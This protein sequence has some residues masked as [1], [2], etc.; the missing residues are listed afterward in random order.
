MLESLVA[1]VLNR[2]LGSYVENFDPNQLKIGIWSGDVKLSNLKLKKE[3]LDKFNLPIDLKCGHLGQLTLQIPWSNLKGLPVKILIED[4]YLLAAGRIPE[5]INVEEDIQRELNVKKQKL[6]SLEVIQTQKNQLEVDADSK[7]QSFVESLTTKII[8]NLQVTIKN[9]HFRYEDEDAFSKYPYAVGATLS[10]LSAVSANGDW[11][12]SFIENVTAISKKLLTLNSLTVYWDTEHPE[13]VYSDDEDEVLRK[14]KEIIAS[15]SSID[16]NVEY[17]LEPV[18]GQ[19]RLTVNKVGSQEN[20]PHYTLDLFFE[21]FK[22]GLTSLQYRDILDTL[23]RVEWYRKTYKYKKFRPTVPVKEDPGKWLKYAFEC[24]YDEIHQRNYK[25]TWE[26]IAKRRDQRVEYVGLWVKKITDANSL[27]NDEKQRIAQLEIDCEYEDLKFYRSMARAKYRESHPPTEPETS[28]KQQGWFSSWWSGSPEESKDIPSD[29]QITEEQ[30]NEFFNAIEFDENKEVADSFDIPRDRILTA[31]GCSL[32][33]GS[34]TIKDSQASPPFAEFISNGGK[35]D[36]F[37]RKDSYY[38]GFKLNEFRVEDGSKTTM[39]KHIVSVKPF[40]EDETSDDTKRD[41]LFQLSYEHNPL[42]E[43]AD[44]ELLAKL[45]SMTIFHNPKFIGQIA[46]FFQPPKAHESTFDS[47]INAAETTFSD[48]TKMTRI[49]IQSAFENHKT[50]NCKMDLQA[51]LIILPVDASNWNS[52]VA[53][54]DAGHISVLSDLVDKDRIDKIRKEKKD[55][56]TDKDWENIGIYMYDKFKLVLQDARILIG[57][58]IKS[59]IEQLNSNGDKPSMI[60]DNLTMNFLIEASIIPNLAE[61]PRIRI[62]GDIPILKAMLNDYQYRIFM[63]IVDMEMIQMPKDDSTD[64]T[65]SPGLG[66]VS[67]TGP[68]SKP[69]YFN[70][71][72][73]TES[74][75]EIHE[76]SV[77]DKQHQVEL[78]F[79]MDKII[80]SLKRCSDPSTYESDVLVD[81]IGDDF[82]LKFYNTSNDMNVDLRLAD[83]SIDDF[84]ENSSIDEFKKLVCHKPNGNTGDDLF[85]LKFKRTLRLVPFNDEIIECYD[86]DIDL[87][88]SDFQA[89]LTRKSVLT[90]LNYSLNTF[91]DPLAPDLPSDKLRHNQ[92]QQVSN[93]PEHI[94]LNLRLKSFNLLLNDYGE[95]LA[96]IVLEDAKVGMFLLP[97]SMKLNATI[98]GFSLIDNFRTA[99]QKLISIQ[100]DDLGNLH[101]ETFDP[102]T[103]IR[104]YGSEFMF[105][106]KSLIVWFMED[107]FNRLYTFLSQFQQMKYVYDQAREAALDQANNVEYPDNTKFQILIRAPI[108]IFPKVLDP[109]T[110]KYDSITANLGEISIVNKF[111]VEDDI[112]FNLMTASLRNTKISSS[113][114]LPN[115]AIQNLDIIDQLDIE[116]DINSYTG[117]TLD[118]P[119]I[120]AKGGI[121]GKEI[122]LTEWQAFTLLQI[123]KYFPRTFETSNVAYSELEEI[124]NDALDANMMIRDKMI[125]SSILSQN[126]DSKIIELPVKDKNVSSESKTSPQINLSFHIP[127]LSMTLFNDTKNSED[128]AT[129][130]L[131]KFA[132]NEIG[133][134]FSLNSDGSYDSNMHVKSFVVDDLREEGKN[135]FTSIMPGVDFTDFQFLAKV[136]SEIINGQANTNLTILID[137]PKLLLAMDYFIALKMFADVVTYEP[138]IHT[139]LDND[140]M[141]GIDQELDIKEQKTVS[142][143]QGKLNYKIQVYNPSIMLLADSEREDTEAI[144]FKIGELMLI[145]NDV[146]EV[147]VDEIG[148]FLCKMSTEDVSKLRL[149]DDFSVNVNIDSNGCSENCFVTKIN[150]S[151]D[152]LVMRLSLRDIRLALEIFNRASDMY[153]EAI[154]SIGKD[155]KTNSANSLGDDISR[156]LSQY[157]PSIISSLSSKSKRSNKGKDGQPAIITKGERLNFSFGGCRLVLIGDVHEL[158]IFDLNT[159]AFTVTASDWSTELSADVQMSS[160]I[161]IFNYSNSSWEPLIEKWPLNVHIEK[162]NDGKLVTNV[163]SKE[164]VEVNITTKTIATISHLAALISENNELKPRG[165]DSPYRIVNQTGYDLNIWIDRNNESLD[166]REN[167]TIV[168]DTETIPWSFEDWRQV[169][170]NLSSDNSS[171]SIGVELIDSEYEPLRNIGLRSEGEETFMLSPISGDHHNRLACDVI[172]RKDNVKQVTLKSTIDINNVTPTDINIGMTNTKG[173]MAIDREIVIPSGKKYSLPIDFVYNGRLVMRPMVE[174]EFYDIS[175]AKVQGSSVA[176]DLN[177]K[178]LKEHDV[179]LECKNVK[180]DQSLD[181]NKRSSQASY[182]FKV[183]ASYD[184]EEPLSKIFPHMIIHIAPPLIIENLLPHDIEFYVYQKDEHGV[185]N[186]LKKGEKMPLHLININKNVVMKIKAL[187]SKYEISQPAIVHSVTSIADTDSE[188]TL[189]SLEDGQRLNLMFRYVQDGKN[190]FKVSIYTPYLIVNRTGKTLKVSEK[191][192]TLISKPGLA[193]TVPIPDMFSFN[194]NSNLSIFKGNLEKNRVSF[195][196][197]NSNVSNSFSVDKVGQSFEVS[198]DS[199]SDNGDKEF[200]IG[201]HISDGRGIYSL[202]KVIH[203]AP[204]FIVKNTLKK[205]IFVS[206]MGIEDALEI[207]PGK[208][209]PVYDMPKIEDKQLVLGFKSDE[210]HMSAPFSITQLGENFIRVKKLNSD[211]HDLLRVAIDSEDASLYIL[212]LDAKNLWP[213]S[214]RNFSKYEFFFYQANP[215]VDKQGNIISDKPFTPIYYKIPPESAMPYA[216]DYPAAEVK[217]LVLRYGSHQRYVQL[218]EIG[219]LLPMKLDSDPKS[220]RSVDLNVI[221]DG[222]V[223]SLAITEYDPK[224]SMYQLKKNNSTSAS[225]SNKG[226]FEATVSDQNYHTEFIFMF[227]GLGISLINKKFRELCYI[228]LNGSELKYSES[229]LYQTA[230][231]KLKW[232]QVDNQLYPSIHPIIIYPTVV[233]KSKIE[234]ENHPIFSTALCRMKDITHGVNYIKFATALLQELSIELDE[235]FLWEL[236]DFSNIPG[237][238]WN[239]DIKDVLWDESLEIPEPPTIRSTNDLYFEALNIQPLQFNLSFVRTDKLNTDDSGTQKNAL[240]VAVD[241]LTMAIGNINEAP[242][243]LSALFLENVRTPLPY[244]LKNITEHYT[245]T[246]LY[247]FYKV[248]G[249]ADVFGNPVG[250]F[251]N[252]S[253]GVM[254]IFYEP[255][256]GYMMKEPQEVGLG[257]AK[258]G[259]SFLKK[260]IF[261]LSDSVSRFSGSVAKGLTAASLD[262]DFQERRMLNRRRNT[263]RHPMDGVSNGASSLYDGITAGFTGLAVAPYQGAAK[264][265]ASGFI[266]GIGKGLWGLPTKTATGVFDFANNISESIKSTTTVFDLGGLEKVRFSRYIPYDGIVIPYSERESRGLFWLKS[267]DGGV[268]SNDCYLGHIVL[269]GGQSACIVTMSRILI[270]N[271]SYLGKNWQVEY[272]NISNITNMDT[273]IT[274]FEKLG[275]PNGK[276]IPIGDKAERRYLYKKITIG[277]NEFNKKCIVAL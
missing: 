9:I 212:V 101:Y 242:V 182:Y 84:I 134:E 260:S 199:N 85:M 151:V 99:P 125:D 75:K 13:S 120:V 123:F 49:G 78:N 177:W 241:I 132:L 109:R 232:F 27:S 154:K 166:K 112:T 28:S 62:S 167:L 243:K 22:V 204:R 89:V 187:N 178:V 152:P 126:N 37:Q 94:N 43:S 144:V 145:N 228:S 215:Y 52:P 26:Y 231:F 257:I 121:D 97:D 172:L 259:L 102:E 160:L 273:G 213:Y 236:L 261:G 233:P 171:T 3:S 15:N 11:V 7:N 207:L 183:H 205:S 83:V 45:T 53:I 130:K 184:K 2:T 108:I 119:D 268:Y 147:K 33:T 17:L 219:S 266:K 96:T 21:Q 128:I 6:E 110:N 255:Y 68:V 269:Q 14:M 111:D 25:S 252:I 146:L 216:W 150:A 91:T 51:P 253:S 194:N 162:Q 192:N 98:G 263:P 153:S 188:I 191:M 201:V 12:P 72:S 114:H 47:L 82:R 135:K 88:I 63:E 20:Q 55:T 54:L 235:D 71:S 277:V 67:V 229:D 35:V 196:I 240:Y 31:V 57:P 244:L 262:K 137:S 267:C 202:T 141:R 10:E 169:R 32:K 48:F 129:K 272:D 77:L 214:I 66:N 161:N 254:D 46:K 225:A 189:K 59:T 275:D 195:K 19:G 156:R 34:F 222:P 92:E 265:G 103:N 93:A 175:V 170:E 180:N 190:G 36:F 211:T 104:P 124:E 159:D 200:N 155:H 237:A 245:Q 117:G 270:I 29:L 246:F 79:N 209:Y 248:L 251:N 127:L 165:K 73:E 131:T 41:P 116:F 115:G 138:I 23:S 197:E 173:E 16:S 193:D 107:S 44:S 234:M 90:L 239:L 223:Q 250:L 106:T 100:G 50:I 148:M 208:A 220:L 30:K 1:G 74:E 203:V 122:L 247:Q 61:F 276:F 65:N 87:D 69:S 105:E 38:I 158:P 4:V 143:S 227:E 140:K 58:N 218:A 81:L 168:K 258:G 40:D 226:E 274:I 179:F 186:V 224:V 185:S 113:F 238:A 118:R 86:Q 149:L 133:L 95:K 174:N 256:Q 210:Q 24:V 164:K 271:I 206:S 8:D 139:D 157:A 217:E 56:Y 198:M 18:I 64:I 80:V 163:F 70:E 221:A 230:T 60:L 136:S 5:S 264:E 176:M 181:T 39:Y 76:D 142:S 42:D 249:S